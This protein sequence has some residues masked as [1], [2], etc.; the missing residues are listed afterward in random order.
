[1]KQTIPKGQLRLYISTVINETFPS[2]PFDIDE[3]VS[4]VK[5]MGGDLRVVALMMGCSDRSVMNWLNNKTQPHP[6]HRELGSFMLREVKKVYKTNTSLINTAIEIQNRLFPI[7]KKPFN[8]QEFVWE[9]QDMGGSYDTVSQLM[10]CQDR[11]LKFWMSGKAQPSDIHI[12]IGILLKSKLLKAILQE[13]FVA[14]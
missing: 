7:S 10:R 12:Q 3:F 13:N 8:L 1:M 2:E 11:T 4:E 14:A 9:I 6:V 5:D